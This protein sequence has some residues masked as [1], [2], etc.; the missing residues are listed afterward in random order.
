MIVSAVGYVNE[1]LD[2][3]LNS[4]Q[5]ELFGVTKIHDYTLTS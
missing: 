1:K 2:N 4:A 5:H 3:M